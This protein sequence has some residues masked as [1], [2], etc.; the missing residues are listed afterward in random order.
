[1]EDLVFRFVNRDGMDLNPEDNPW[2]EI[3]TVALTTP[4]LAAQA[5]KEGRFLGHA[6]EILERFKRGGEMNWPSYSE[7]AEQMMKYAGLDPQQTQNEAERQN[8][9]IGY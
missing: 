6:A 9:S 8:R 2:Q 3:E 4:D 5:K 7:V 1:M